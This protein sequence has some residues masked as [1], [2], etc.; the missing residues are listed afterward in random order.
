MDTHQLLMHCPHLIV[1]ELEDDDNHFFMALAK[2]FSGKNPVNLYRQLPC[3]KSRSLTY[4]LLEE[5]SHAWHEFKSMERSLSH[6]PH[7]GPIYV[8]TLG[9]LH[10][11]MHLNES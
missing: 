5:S 9:L 8:L 4:L 1:P 3:M 7:F 10:L 2:T 6:I 11:F